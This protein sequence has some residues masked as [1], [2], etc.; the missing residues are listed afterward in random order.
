MYHKD[1]LHIINEIAATTQMRFV[2]LLAL[3]SGESNF[4][5]NDGFRGMGFVITSYSI[6]YTKLYEAIEAGQQHL[7]EVHVL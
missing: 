2:R 3:K 4:L 5:Q 1:S 6:H 7:E